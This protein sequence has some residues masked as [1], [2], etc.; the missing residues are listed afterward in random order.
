MNNVV[1][2][3]D[4]KNICTMDENSSNTDKYVPTSEMRLKKKQNDVF[5]G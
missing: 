1:L 5:Y 3:T 2:I 4:L